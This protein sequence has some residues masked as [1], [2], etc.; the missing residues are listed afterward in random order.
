MIWISEVAAKVKPFYQLG[1]YVNEEAKGSLDNNTWAL[2][3]NKAF[4]QEK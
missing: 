1:Q 3:K 4:T 2:P